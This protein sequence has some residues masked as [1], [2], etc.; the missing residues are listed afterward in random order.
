MNYRTRE[1][2][3]AFNA[4]MRALESQ[5]F[6]SGGWDATTDKTAIVD[7]QLP[8]HEHRIA[9]YMDRNLDIE[10]RDGYRRAVGE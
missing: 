7:T 9:G 8:P 4:K 6:C 3:R 1:H 10:W 2:M 5:G